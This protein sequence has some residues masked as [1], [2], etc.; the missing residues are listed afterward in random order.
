MPKNR[1]KLINLL[2]AEELEGSVVGRVLRW[3]MTTFRIIVIVTEMIVMAAFLSRFWLDAKN[4]DLGDS[5]RT[6]AAQV[7]AQKDFETEF[8]DVQKRLAIFE[9]LEKTTPPSEIVAKIVSRLPGGVNLTTITIQEKGVQIRGISGS[10]FGIAQFAS[11]LTAEELFKSVSIG[12][13]NSA[14]GNQLAT[15]FSINITF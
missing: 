9:S 7:S 10:E 13:I 8:R 11:N 2:P 3:A 4:S 12:A 15:I 5:I 1:N 6:K 14:E